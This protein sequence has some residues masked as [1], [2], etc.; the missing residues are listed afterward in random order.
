MSRKR[1]KMR[2][3][4]GHN[5]GHINYNETG[6]VA[7]ISLD[8]FL[9]YQLAAMASKVSREFAKT[10][11]SRFGITIPE[12]RVIFHLHTAGPVSIR[13]IYQRV[14]MDKS[15]VSRAASRLEKAELI[16]K[17]INPA[18][19]RLVELELTDKGRTLMDEI[20]PLALDFESQLMSKLG[21]GGPKFRETLTKYL[22]ADT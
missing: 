7:D 15:K 19:R 13:E 21:V 8:S 20:I 9:P 12:W 4:S 5:Q 22:K 10:Y 2:G 3:V 1:L 6:H 11:V 14:D 16:T 18:D 17:K